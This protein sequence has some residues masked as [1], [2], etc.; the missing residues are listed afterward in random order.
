MVHSLAI[1]SLFSSGSN[2]NTREFFSFHHIGITHAEITQHG[3]TRS[4]ARFLYD[5][6]LHSNHTNESSINQATYFST[7]HTV[8]DLYELSYPKFDSFEVALYSLPF[9]LILDNI[10]TQDVLVDFDEKTKHVST[11]HYDSEAFVNG[12]R[13]ILQFRQISNQLNDFT[14]EYVLLLFSFSH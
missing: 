10:M 5:T 11:A 4:L 7:E 2:K 1:V 6:R 13:R 3:I 14:F 12:S 9:K 8:D